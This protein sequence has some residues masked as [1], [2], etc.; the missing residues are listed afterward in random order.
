M[1]DDFHG[2]DE[3]DVFM[4]T[5]RKV[6]PDRQVVDLD[7]KEAIFHTVFDLD[8]RYQVPGR[9]VRAEATVFA[10]SAPMAAPSRTGAGSTTTTA[11][12]WWRSA[13]T[14]TWA[15]PGKMPM[16]RSIPQKFSALGIRIGVNYIVYAMTH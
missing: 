2:T 10:R 14:W 11:A 9:P 15:I 5:M 4:E 1:C 16:N 8:E 12:S 7:P 6:F 13:T 3:W